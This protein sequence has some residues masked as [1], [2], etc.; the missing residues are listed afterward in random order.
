MIWHILP[1]LSA[2]PTL[3]EMHSDSDNQTRLR[4]AKDI[5]EEARCYRVLMI[6][7]TSFFADYGCHVRILEEARILQE[8]GHRVTIATYQTGG[9]VPGLDIRRSLPIPWRS[10]YVVG[11]SRHKIAFDA[12]LGLKT[13]QLLARER[14]DVVHAHLHEGALIGL[15]A[16]RLFGLPLVF[17]F[18][19]SMTGE[20]LDHHFLKRHGVA[21]LLLR[22]L[23]TRI[24]R[25]VPAILTSTANAR[26]L[27]VQEFGCQPARICPLPD[28]VDTD[29]FRP[30]STYDPADRA[31]LR[32]ELGIPGSRKLIVYLGLLAEYQGTGLLLEAMRRVVQERQDVHLLLMGFP[33]L[34]QYRQKAE[35]LGIRDFV[36]LTGRI[37]YPSAPAYLALGDLAAAP[38]LSLTE[39]AGKLLNYMAVSLPV[40]AFDTPVAREYLGADGALAVHGDVGSLAA[41]LLAY[42]HLA[43]TDP[44]Q[45]RRTGLRLRQRAVQTFSWDQAGRRIVRAYREL[46]GGSTV[47]QTAQ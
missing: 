47:M 3:N 31:A 17:D 15:V 2:C 37:P 46:I 16:G 19:G 7:P 38:K 10:D 8:L 11:S 35:S 45:L 1:C 44:E 34:D 22:W 28:C 33:N 40:V 36:T 27:L 20:M 41:N 13:F 42:A 25:G 12:L 9:A 43:D 21:H 5:G 6:A 14:F 32:R 26:S 24:D 29:M 4:E 39:G 18:Q 23:E 30:A